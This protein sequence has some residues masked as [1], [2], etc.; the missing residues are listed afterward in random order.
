MFGGFG[1][2]PFLFTSTLLLIVATLIT[3]MTGWVV[4]KK[5]PPEFKDY[6]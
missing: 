1:Y 4:R 2:N 6:Y 3:F 5:I